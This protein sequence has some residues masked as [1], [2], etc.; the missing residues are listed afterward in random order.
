MSSTSGTLWD[1]KKNVTSI[2]IG[3]WEG[4]EKESKAE[5]YF[6]TMT[7]YSKYGKRHRP[8]IQ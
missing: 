8:K 4:V 6:K 1:C 7:K 3:V 5:K 2:E